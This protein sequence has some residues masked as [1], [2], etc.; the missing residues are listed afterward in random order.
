MKGPELDEIPATGVS[1]LPDERFGDNF[2]RLVLHKQ[3]VFESIDRVLGEDIVLGPIGAGPGRVLARITARGRYGKTYGE[4][5]P[6]TDALG[7]KV[8]L[9]VALSFEL[10]LRV[11]TVSFDADV[12][13]PLT[14]RMYVEEPLTVVWDIKPPSEEEVTMTVQ[15]DKRRSAALQKVAGIDAELRRFIIRFVA[16]ELDKPHVRRATRIDLV[17]VIDKAWPEIA[18]QF[19]PY[20]PGDRV[21]E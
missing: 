14:L 9:P 6:D 4:E 21:A 16:R 12:L 19:L 15:T 11:D 8:F 5:L 3:R 18:A 13:L 2:M 10:D 20:G 7:Y 17:D 1:R